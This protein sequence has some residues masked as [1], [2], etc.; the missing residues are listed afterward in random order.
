MNI[1][2]DE[3]P[4]SINVGGLEFPINT[5]FRAGIAFEIMLEEGE[6]NPLKIISPFFSDI[7][8]GLFKT[9]FEQAFDA[10]LLYYRCG[11][12]SKSKGKPTQTR[13]PYSFKN[14][15]NAIFSDFWYYYNIDLSQEGLHWWAFRS[16]LEGLP[17]NSEFKQRIY[18]RTCE[19][20]GMSKKERERV[21]KIRSKIEIK[22]SLNEEMTL[23]QRNI[24]MLAYMAKRR[25]ETGGVEN[26]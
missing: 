22:N 20:K 24:K 8:D 1:L 9:D 7:P 2:T 3:L 23:E 17:E 6:R 11:K 25:K 26:G 13:Q 21:L 15:S 4:K 18:Y 14:D 16:L 19:L 10:L 5:D 12:K